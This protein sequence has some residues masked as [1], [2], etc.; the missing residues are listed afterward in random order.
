MSLLRKLYYALSPDMRFIARRIWYLPSD[1][2]ALATG[3]RDDMTPPKGM[4]FI[5]AG[6]FVKQGQNLM[7][8]LIKYAGLKP[9]AAVLDIGC[10][11]GRLAVPLTKYLS[12]KGSYDGFDI[13]KKGIDWCNSHISPKYPNFKFLHIDLI[14][15]LYNKKTDLEA[16]NFVFP[17]EDDSFDCIALTSVFTHMLP[18][19]VYNYLA[20]IKRVMKPKGKCFATYF[21]L[22]DEIEAKMEKGLTNFNF[23]YSYSDFRLMDKNVPEANVAYRE[24]FLEMMYMEYNL[25]C[26]EVC[27]GEWSNSPDSFFFQDFHIIEK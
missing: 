25:R 13:V 16:K 23:P 21:L 6:D 7:D 4:I 10:G 24:D 12:D 11:I 2:L 22:N 15:S 18:A 27:Y 14:N 9:D 17:Y 5:G 26:T 1:L 8:L 20:E 19:D 3:K